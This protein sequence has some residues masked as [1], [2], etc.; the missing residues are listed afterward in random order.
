MDKRSKWLLAAVLASGLIA[1]A[2][3]LNLLVIT[4]GLLVLT[5][6]FRTWQAWRQQ[7]K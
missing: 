3:G 4:L 6:I 1:G 2:Y 5:I 7:P